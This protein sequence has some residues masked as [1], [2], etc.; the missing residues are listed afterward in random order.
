VAAGITQPGVA[1]ST[2]FLE[3]DSHADADLDGVLDVY[4]PSDIV[5]KGLGSGDVTDLATLTK[6]FRS[7]ATIQNGDGSGTAVTTFEAQNMR[8]LF[9]SGK[10]YA[11]STVGSANRW[12]KLGQKVQGASG[13]PGG[14]SGCT[15]DFGATTTIRG[16]MLLYGST[17]RTAVGAMNLQPG[18]S[19]L[20]AEI[21]SCLLESAGNISIGTAAAILQMIYNVEF[22]L[23][24]TGVISNL[25]AE[26]IERI[27]VVLTGSNLYFISTGAAFN[28][29]DGIF[30]GTPAAA[31]I[32]FTGGVEAHLI[33]HTWSG[34][35]PKLDI[36]ATGV[37]EWGSFNTLTLDKD[38][39][40][41]VAAV[42]VRIVDDATSEV[43]FDGVSDANGGITF[44]NDPA[45]S[46]R[47]VFANAVRLA[48]HSGSGPVVTEERGPWTVQ[49]N[50]TGA[51]LPA[52][53]GFSYK[54]AWK[55]SDLPNG[56]GKQYERNMVEAIPLGFDDAPAP[57]VDPIRIDALP[58]PA[59]GMIQIEAEVPEVIL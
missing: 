21:V 48:K 6:S 10:T 9:D 41:V 52:Y 2:I 54:M 3:D 45:G 50:Q 51:T 5:A 36:A 27:W 28:V 13:K 24:G 32:R 20:S 42:P 26:E 49:V 39:G 46:G 16:N 58:I 17:L 56:Y 4:H 29:R 38:T 31:D 11:V 47:A 33:A 37:S 22:V 59:E 19:G 53:P 25:N 43:V 40:L 1:G 34:N 12:T 55:Y 18:A 8:L 15:I 57:A 23:G 14:R 44:N 30:V 35:A 7:K